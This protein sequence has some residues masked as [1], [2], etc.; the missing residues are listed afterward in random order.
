[1]PLPLEKRYFLKYVANYVSNHGLVFGN[2][3]HLSVVA[4]DLDGENYPII[5]NWIYRFIPP[6]GMAVEYACSAKL[7]LRKLGNS[8]EK[9]GNR[10]EK[11]TQQRGGKARR[12]AK[13]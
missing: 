8:Q 7:Q 10:I 1:M 6:N 3:A 12:S 2:S 5:C 13:T 11:G 4:T 9:R